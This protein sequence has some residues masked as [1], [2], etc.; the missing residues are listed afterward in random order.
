ML[1]FGLT[2]EQLKIS[3]SCRPAASLQCLI[4]MP[5]ATFII[6]HKGENTFLLTIDHKDLVLLDD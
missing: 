2:S 4:K 3:F 1:A 6:G 5:I